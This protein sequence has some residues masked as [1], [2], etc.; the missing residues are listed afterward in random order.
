MDDLEFVSG[1]CDWSAA[2][3][4]VRF[5]ANGP[6]GLVT[7]IATREALAELAH[8]GWMDLTDE[9]AMEIFSDNEGTFLQIARRKFR[10]LP[11][12]RVVIEDGDV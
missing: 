1:R 11:G 9:Q 4:G 8:V 10:L 12:D 3:D 2:N 5:Y 6:D 7:L